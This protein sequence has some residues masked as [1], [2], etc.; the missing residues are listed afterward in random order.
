MVII[1]LAVSLFKLRLYILYFKIYF[2]GDFME[3]DYTPTAT[4]Q[5]GISY[6]AIANKLY[7]TPL[8]QGLDMDDIISFLICSKSAC[9]SFKP[10]EMIFIES[11]EPKRLPVLVEG[12]V[13]IGRDS[14]SGQRT[15]IA[16]FNNSGDSFGD[17]ILFLDKKSYGLFAQATSLTKVLFIPKSIMDKTCIHACKHHS[18]IISNLLTIF[19]KN[20]NTLRIRLEILSCP[21]LRQKIEKTL[22][23]WSEREN[24]SYISMSRDQLAE[25]LCTTRPS[26]SRELMKMKDEGL[27]SVD[28][29]KI[30]RNPK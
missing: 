29:R 4:T 20:A 22:I 10:G 25:F 11:D 9:K 8:F 21:T 6:K 3:K 1:T 30:Y 26:I 13:R 16:T 23:L 24:K 12:N 14:F 27:I 7:G 15:T 5:C 18:H 28:G 19:A 2:L 17:V